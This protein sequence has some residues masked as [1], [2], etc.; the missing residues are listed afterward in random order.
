MAFTTP[1][2]PNLLDFT[3]F[4]Y[5]NGIPSADLPSGSLATVTIDTSGNLTA[6]SFTGTVSAGMA[7]T[8]TGITDGTTLA[9]W[10]STSLTGTVSPVPSAAVSDTAV[11]VWSA[12]LWWSLNQAENT[13]LPPPPFL[14]PIIW[15]L[16][17]YNLGLHI[18]I[19]IAQDSPGQTFFT[20][21]RTQFQIGS[22][23]SGVLANASDEGTGAQLV[24][25]EAFKNLSLANLDCLKTPYG[26]EYLMYIQEYGPTIVGVC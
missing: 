12:Y 18:L 11:G 3:T 17:T 6:A 16:A 26:R 10:D 23:I 1:T 15:V 13:V 20:N 5:A 22:F 7:L 8:G 9:T 24:V 2:T 4:V 19:R 21:L 25:A 14:V